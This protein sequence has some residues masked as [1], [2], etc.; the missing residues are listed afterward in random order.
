MS[1]GGAG[2]DL[3]GRVVCFVGTGTGGLLAENF[4]G[5]GPCSLKVLRHLEMRPPAAAQPTLRQNLAAAGHKK[6]AF[7]IH[8]REKLLKGE[9]LF[10]L[11]SNAQQ[12]NKSTLCLTD[13]V[14]QK[15]LMLGFQQLLEAETVIT[16][17]ELRDWKLGNV[18]SRRENYAEREASDVAS[19]NCLKQKL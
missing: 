9:E 18:T 4:S 17:G 15:H 16:F 11:H 5:S 8:G 3:G 6:A 10:I 14:M 12:L 19:N 7:W 1:R 13:A 2:G